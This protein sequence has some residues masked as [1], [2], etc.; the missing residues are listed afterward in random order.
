MPRSATVILWP[1]RWVMASWSLSAAWTSAKAL[2]CSAQPNDRAPHDI[3][4]CVPVLV[5]NLFMVCAE[6]GGV[7]RTSY[8]PLTARPVAGRPVVGNLSV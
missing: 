6:T 2:R 4:S 3:V 5:G 8:L 1:P 7:A